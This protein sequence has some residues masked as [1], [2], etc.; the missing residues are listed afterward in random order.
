[1]VKEAL[2]KEVLAKNAAH[3]VK[4]SLSLFLII[5]GGKESIIK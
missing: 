2:K 4:T 3:I 1:L 5:L